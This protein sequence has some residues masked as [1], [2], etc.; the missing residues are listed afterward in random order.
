L[1]SEIRAF[2]KDGKTMEDA[3]ENVG[4]SARDDWQLFDEFHKRNIST[5]FAE[6]EWEDD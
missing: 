4:L 5:A 3:M 2:I 6:L 1:Q